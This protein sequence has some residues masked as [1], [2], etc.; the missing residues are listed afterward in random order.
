M[1]IVMVCR[2]YSGIARDRWA[3]AGTPAIVKLIERLE[4]QGYDTTVLFLE[5]RYLK[6]S[7]PRDME[8]VYGRFRH[9]RFC[10]VGW[11]G[12]G[13]RPRLLSELINTTRQ[14]F[15]ILSHLGKP[16]DILYFD[17]GHLA[18]AALTALFRRGVVW[19][20][21]GVTSFL[22]ARD[23]RRP[24]GGLYLGIARLLVRAPFGAIICT[25]EGS[26]WYRLFSR[27]Q[28]DRNLA[29]WTNGVESLDVS[30]PSTAPMAE[31]RREA[32]RA[33]G[34]KPDRPVIGYVGR[35]T[36]AKG[37]DLFAAMLARLLENGVEVSG[38]IV[39]EGED[40]P[41]AH[42][43]LDAGGAADRVVCTGQLPHSEIAR[44]LQAID[45]FVSPAW[46]G[47]LSNATLEAL[48]AGKCTVVLEPDPVRGTDMTIA[49]F[50][51]ADVMIRAR[52]DD[53]EASL[54]EIIASLLESPDRIRSYENEARRFAAERLQGWGPRID[55]EISLLQCIADG[56]QVA[57]LLPEQTMAAAGAGRRP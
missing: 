6:H 46:N 7:G 27:R 42:R 11:R 53:P 10:H 52:R 38:L 20:C 56:H 33:V 29:V 8:T 45:I 4:G 34:L 13:P 14:Y 54:T 17:R 39:G 41:E 15:A 18:Y 26:P 49:E 30:D 31:A 9:V 1:K 37:I 36:K 2:R 32:K 35:V 50:V 22:L 21:L 51:P 28:L 25:N 48:S 12:L 44:H 19:R 40:L 57:P 55:R 5:K 43:L 47:S 23:A 3:P 24:L 16:S